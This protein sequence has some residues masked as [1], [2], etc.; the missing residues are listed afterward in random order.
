MMLRHKLN[1]LIPTRRKIRRYKYLNV[2]GQL[3][4]N[5]E[6]WQL[7]PNS[8][9]NAVS[10]GLFTCFMPI[11]FQMLMAAT[12]AIIFRANLPISVSLVWISNPIT[13]SPMFYFAYKL[14]NSILIFA[15]NVLANQLIISSLLPERWVQLWKPLI[16]GLV[17]CGMLSAVIGNIIVRITW[18]I[19]TLLG[20]GNVQ[21]KQLQE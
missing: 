17:A 9:A 19:Y 21:D 11:P 8:V 12:L 15:P 3:H 10:I 14:G 16:I 6:L 1:K 18:R 20:N 4:L 7:H 13:F 5:P 2:F